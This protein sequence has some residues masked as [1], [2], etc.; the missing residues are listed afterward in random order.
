MPKSGGAGDAG[1]MLVREI[2]RSLTLNYE[3]VGFVD[4]DPRKQ[5]RRIHGIKVLGGIDQ[6]PDLCRTRRA[7]ELLIAIPSATGT[8]MRRIIG[9]C[10]AAQVQFSTIPSLG[11][12]KEGHSTFSTVRRV[13]I[14]DLLRREPVRIERAEVE[15]FV[16]G[17]R[18]L[19]T[20]AGEQGR[21][22]AEGQ[23]RG[24]AG[25]RGEAGKLDQGSLIRSST[26]LRTVTRSGAAEA[27]TL[28]A[29]PACLW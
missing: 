20:G 13:N 19:V 4:D 6:L 14:E 16:R 2:D 22:T 8:E 1:E 5:G 27:T 26:S 11:E 18:V 15:R 29:L 9:A 3:V 12:L 7:E 21:R 24:G 23:G 25:E 10:R 28:S 17:K